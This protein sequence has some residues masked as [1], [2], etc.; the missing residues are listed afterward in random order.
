M[1]RWSWE[2]TLADLASGRGAALKRHAF[3]LCGDTLTGLIPPEETGWP[4]STGTPPAV[5]RRTE[6]WL[7]PASTASRYPPSGVAWIAPCELIRV[8]LRIA[9]DP[10]LTQRDHG[11]AVIALAAIAG[12]CPLRSVGR[13]CRRC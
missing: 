1:V 5:T 7:L 12:Y 8:A 6:I 4:T 11:L 2:Q 3:L 10:P 9:A 13:C